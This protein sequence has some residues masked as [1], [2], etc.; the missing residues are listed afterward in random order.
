MKRKGFTLIELLVVVAIIAILAAMLLPALAQARENARRAVC[1][2]NLKQ[3]GL[4]YAMYAT[5]FNDLIPP[6]YQRATFGDFGIYLWSNNMY[7]NSVFLRK[8]GKPEKRNI[9]IIRV[10]FSALLLRLRPLPAQRTWQVFY[11]TLK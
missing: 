11:L 2:N 1:L 9:L 4:A 8:V 6:R 10:F 5:D 3:I 7:G